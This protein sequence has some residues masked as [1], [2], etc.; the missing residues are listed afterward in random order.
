MQNFRLSTA[1][2]KFHQICTL[3]DSFCWK[4]T[5]MSHDPEHWRKIWR[6]TDLLFQKWQE[7][8][9]IW[10]EHSKVYKTCT[11]I[12]SYCAK[13]LMFDL[14]KYRGVIFHDTEGWCKIWRKTDLWFGKWNEE[15][16][17]FSPQYLKVSK[18]GVWW[19]PL[20]QSRKS[21]NLKFT[22]ELCVMTMKNDAKF[23]EESTCRFKIDMRNWQILT[24]ALESLKHF[25]FNVLLL[26]KLYIVWAKK[27]QRSYLSGH[28]RVIQNVER[29]RLVV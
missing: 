7:F 9:E 16:G 28:W 14:K 22:K 18:L 26:S 2:V 29:N 23:E 6:K 17:K 13:Y 19:G 4:Y 8:G 15:Y 11:F 10:P 21:I 1:H 3:I 20:I 24:R 12:C 5:V 27:V 25:H